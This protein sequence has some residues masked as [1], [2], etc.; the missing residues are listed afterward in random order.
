M[1]DGV[2][3]ATLKLEPMRYPE[4]NP[5]LA[6][7]R[8]WDLASIVGPGF[9]MASVTIGNGEIFS[10]TRGGAVFG[11][12]LLWTFM[13]G[14]VMKAAIVYA[15]GRYIVLTGEHPFARFG[16]ILPGGR[17]GG[18]AQHWFATAMGILS[19]VCFPAWSVAYILALSQLVPW[20]FGFGD[21]GRI[22]WIGIVLSLIAWAT[23]FAPDFSFAE[24]LNGIIVGI[25]VFFALIALA[26]CGASWLGVAK[27]LIPSFNLSYPDWV[28]SDFP[29][30]AERPVIL[31]II[32]Y[33]GALGGGV[34]D[35]IGYIGTFREKGWGMLGRSDT[36]EL[37]AKLQTL[38]MNEVIPIATD[39]ENEQL[40]AYGVKAVKIDTVTS[41]VAVA[42]FALTFM[43]LGAVVLGT[44]ALQQ[45][46]DDTNI[47]QAQAN[48]FTMIHPAL[49]WVY[50]LAVFS[51]FWGSQQA[52][53]TAVYPYTF[54]EAFA[55]AFPKLNDP[56][57][58]L[59]VKLILSVY[60][61]GGAIILALT[62]VSYVQV[63]TFAGV[64]GGVFGLGIWGFMQ[65]Y[66]DQKMLPP[67][68]KMKPF[69][70]ALVLFSSLVLFVMGLIALLQFFGINLIG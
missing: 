57:L 45:V 7:N 55:P 64:L 52:L 44:G 70:I 56:K 2:A 62:G 69:M 38:G 3:G 61:L 63:I 8:F 29:K 31:E 24:R 51:A 59:R 18:I 12:A 40:G 68:L 35:Y 37:Q 25:M 1:S 65:V 15:G 47:I 5:K 42:I 53:L 23:I 41:F 34:Y 50:V 13:L 26:V 54:R 46:P 67:H 20:A 22:L 21:G 4:Q 9:I 19:M 32:G 30:V 27:G 58:F 10:A 48:F 28:S 49:K 17:N 60:I 33:L 39:A 6:S 36:V 14:A 66:M 16:H 11:Y 43:I